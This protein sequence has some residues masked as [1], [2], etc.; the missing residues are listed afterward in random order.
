DIAQDQPEANE[1]DCAPGETWPF[2]ER[3][4]V[5]GRIDVVGQIAPGVEPRRE[6]LFVQI[7]VA[8]GDKRSHIR[9]LVEVAKAATAER[10]CRVRSTPQAPQPDALRP[11][12]H[13]FDEV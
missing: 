12:G 6:E 8:G 7:V 5:V 2:L 4:V 9:L 11:D 3:A 13:E 1:Y 10:A